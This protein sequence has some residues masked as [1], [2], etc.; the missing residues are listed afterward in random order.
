MGH[1][2][3]EFFTVSS[4]KTTVLKCPINLIIK[5]TKHFSLV[6]AFSS[7]SKCKKSVKKVENKFVKDF[8]FVQKK[9]FE[10]NHL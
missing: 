7:S 9:M 8:F 4:D 1:D 10:P 6:M 2:E 5:K 3:I